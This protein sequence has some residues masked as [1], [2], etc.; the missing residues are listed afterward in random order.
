MA[1]AVEQCENLPQIDEVMGFM[2]AGEAL[3]Y[4]NDHP[5]DLAILDIR[6][7]ETDGI[8]FTAQIRQMMPRGA[9]LFM[10]AH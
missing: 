1:F 8:T 5:V 7:P 6:M 3:G 2:S 4:L 9:I 10:T